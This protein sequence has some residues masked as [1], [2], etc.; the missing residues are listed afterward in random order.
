VKKPI[1]FLIVFFLSY[2]V[3]FFPSQSYAVDCRE[4]K[5]SR[6]SIF[7]HPIQFDRTTPVTLDIYGVPE[8]FR[9]RPFQFNLVSLEQDDDALFANSYN[10]FTVSFDE[11]GNFSR[12]FTINEQVPNIPPGSYNFNLT[13]DFQPASNQPYQVQV[14]NEP[15]SED[16]SL[17]ISGEVSCL[18]L[19]D[20]C[21]G[22]D[23]TQQFCNQYAFCDQEQNPARVRLPTLKP[24]ILNNADCVFLETAGS[25]C[26]EV[27]GDLS[28]ACGSELWSRH[29]SS[30]SQDPVVQM[31]M[32]C[33][34]EFECRVATGLEDKSE[35]DIFRLCSQVS[36]TDR[37]ACETCLVRDKGIWTS[38]GCIEF[39]G[40][41]MIRSLIVTALGLAGGIGLLM[42]IA[43]GAMFTMSRNDPKKVGDAKELLTSVVI[44]LVFI[45]FSVTVLQFIGVT[46]LRIPGLG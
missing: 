3:T 45:A 33:Q 38:L 25:T 4:N 17:Q 30:N 39:E 21:L 28:H 23:P 15:F 10:L 41:S 43:A 8:I 18:E 2:I 13:Q 5:I 6:L 14:C 46:V 12:T 37:S 36:S 26:S 7:I 35:S 22:G 32:C 1:I 20:P 34:S 27:S 44:G 19:G 9:N 29:D 24:D 42:I 11:N 16:F 31:T 40:S